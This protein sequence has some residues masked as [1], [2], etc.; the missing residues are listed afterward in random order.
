MYDINARNHNA[1]NT[2]KIVRTLSKNGGRATIHLNT[3][4]NPSKAAEAFDNR[5]MMAAAVA[6]SKHW[7]AARWT[8]LYE[9]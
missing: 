8:L 6:A 3:T 1:R 9:L 4:L 5:R 7:R 2:I